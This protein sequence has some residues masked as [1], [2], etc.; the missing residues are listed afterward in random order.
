MAT[1]SSTSAALNS[2]A[3]SPNVYAQEIPYI[4][5]G[6][7]V[8]ID[9]RPWRERRSPSGN[10]CIHEPHWGRALSCWNTARP[11]TH[12]REGNT[13]G[14]RISSLWRTGFRL[15]SMNT[16]S[17]PWSADVAAQTM[18]LEL[19]P[20]VNLAYTGIRVPLVTSP[21]N[22]FLC[23]LPWS[24]ETTSRHWRQPETV[25]HYCKNTY[26]VA[27]QSQTRTIQDNIFFSLNT[28]LN[29]QQHILVTMV[30]V[31]LKKMDIQGGA[32]L[33]SLSVYT[34]MMIQVIAVR[35]D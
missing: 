30:F 23:H 35:S 19:P 32:F 16:D 1:D 4:F 18:A 15:P 9:A 27:Q 17:E 29:S 33:F 14:P 20:P 22:S 34:P 6:I 31:H 25:S 5:N 7:Q 24:T 28:V 12:S 21:V 13:T 3:V 26:I 10:G 2:C 8:G 11:P